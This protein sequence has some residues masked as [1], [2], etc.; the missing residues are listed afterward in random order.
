MKSLYQLVEKIIN[1]EG[2]E[3]EQVIKD[4]CYTAYMVGAEVESMGIEIDEEKSTDGKKIFFTYPEK[5][6]GFD[7][8]S[9]KDYSVDM[10][11]NMFKE[12]VLFS[13]GISM[14][15]LNQFDKETLDGLYN[16]TYE[17]F[18]VSLYAAP[19]IGDVLT[20]EKYES[21]KSEHEELVTEAMSSM[22]KILNRA[23]DLARYEKV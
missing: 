7:I 18:G 17:D 21:K 11:K 3:R 19:R 16:M 15:E 20:K 1:T 22:M 2:P 6:D 4:A 13:I 12:T 9:P 8:A 14:I 5:Y 10:V 23:V